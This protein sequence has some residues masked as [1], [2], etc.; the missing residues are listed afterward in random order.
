LYHH[1]FTWSTITNVHANYQNT[2]NLIHFYSLRS[3]CATGASR[4]KSLTQYKAAIMPAPKQPK[5]PQNSLKIWPKLSHVTQF[6]ALPQTQWRM[7]RF[8]HHGQLWKISIAPPHQSQANACIKQMIETNDSNMRMKQANDSNKWPT[9]SSGSSG[10]KANTCFKQ[11]K[12]M[13]MILNGG[14]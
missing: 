1:A 7:D 13:R 10:S 14:G 2:E 8:L 9:D 3:E 4:A 12:E 6:A 11:A 5:T